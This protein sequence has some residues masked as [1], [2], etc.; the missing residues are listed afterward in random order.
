MK[1]S[2]HNIFGRKSSADRIFASVENLVFNFYSVLPGAIAPPIFDS[3]IKSQEWDL[4]SSWTPNDSSTCQFPR[5]SSS[6]LNTKCR[7]CVDLRYLTKHRPF[8]QQFVFGSRTR[9]NRAL[10]V[11]RISGLD[12]LPTNKHFATILWKVSRSELPKF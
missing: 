4:K 11:R 6:Y 9:L 1:R 12:R 10:T 3:N 8:S 7:C 2:T 5:P